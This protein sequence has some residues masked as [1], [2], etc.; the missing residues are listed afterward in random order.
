MEVKITTK[1]PLFQDPKMFTK[2]LA[3]S[4][5]RIALV[6]QKEAIKAY[7][8]KRITDKLPSMIVDSFTIVNTSIKK[9]EA[10]TIVFAGGGTAPYAKFVDEDHRLVNGKLWSSANSDAP[11]LFMK[12]GRDAGEIASTKIIL[13]EFGKLR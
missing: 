3:K 12:A 6:V 10:K 13:E 11:Y 4:A 9:T 7:M 8:K 1:G 2:A 5:N